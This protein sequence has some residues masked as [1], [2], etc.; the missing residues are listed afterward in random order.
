MDPPNQVGPDRT[1]PGGRRRPT[2]SRGV[3]VVLERSS[4]VMAA[5]GGGPAPEDVP[6]DA[7]M[8]KVLAAD[9]RRDI[10]RLLQKRRMTL[11][12]LATALD[13]K[14]ATVLEHLKR[15]T[16]AG[17]VRRH[18][19]ERLWVYYELTT[20]GGRLLNPGRT[21]FYIVMGVAAAAALL[22][23]G[24]ATVAL[25][26]PFFDHDVAVTLREEP[27]AGGIPVS[28]DVALG[29]DPR[30]AQA[31]LLTP[32]Q[33]RRL[34]PD[35]PP[36]GF[37]LHVRAAA[38]GARLEAPRAVP[39][40]DYLLYVRGEDGDNRDALVAVHLPAYD[41][42]GPVRGTLGLD[43]PLRFAATRDGAP[44]AGRLLLQERG[45]TVASFPLEAGA[46]T[47]GPAEL[48]ALEAGTY[49]LAVR[50]AGADVDV[51]LPGRSLAVREAVVGLVPAHVL[52]GQPF[53]LAVTLGGH[54]GP[55]PEVRVAGQAVPARAAGRGLQAEVPA[56][57]PGEADV[58]VGRLHRALPVHPDLRLALHAMEDGLE[59]RVRDAQGSPLAGVQ[60]TLGDRRLGATDAEGRV[61]FASPGSG[62]MTLKLH[63][64]QGAPSE[65]G[66]SFENGGV[67]ELL[68][69][70]RVTTLTQPSSQ[71]VEAVVA[72]EGL[73]PAL[74][75][76]TAR[77][78]GA[79]WASEALR[80]D[81]GAS[82]VVRFVL[83]EGSGRVEVQADALDLAPIA[84]SRGSG[85]G[86]TPA[87]GA[88][89]MPTASPVS[90]DSL[91]RDVRPVPTSVTPGAA[92]GANSMPAPEVPIPW[93]L[94]P[95]AVAGAALLWRR[96]RAG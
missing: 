77:V 71:A 43:G 95:L 10:L 26:D 7:D 52:E 89:A 28:L 94:V 37:P 88:P 83:P 87:F 38:G 75:T 67:S 59:L 12:E 64:A 24:L 82:T 8:L 40:G 50:P 41:A 86:P 48:D 5:V 55:L 63:T 91:S 17:L 56:L 65:R 78:D 66:L 70:L 92:H 60:A 39:P 27:V 30:G 2:T 31:W 34:D 33:A 1:E 45:A 72:N 58:Q 53:T 81:G 61:A 80:L 47:V 46:A 18:E 73:G 51:P 68:P 9:T 57:A 35:A 32:D 76:V 6:L 20:Q 85:A 62:R 44:A 54:E 14:K 69:R 29:M 79:L 11:T 96:R 16:D 42:A 23:G 90:D 93:L 36:E 19:D 3:H 84:I 25:V 74:A 13:L 21:R 15:L 22:V 49:Q 4:E